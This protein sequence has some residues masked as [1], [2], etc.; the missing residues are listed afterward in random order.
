MGSIVSIGV[1][2]LLLMGV[3]IGSSLELEQADRTITKTSNN[4]LL[5]NFSILTNSFFILF[6]DPFAIHSKIANILYPFLPNEN[7]HI[8]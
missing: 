1:N 8:S 4:N 6:L 2:G 5:V 7:L 3:F